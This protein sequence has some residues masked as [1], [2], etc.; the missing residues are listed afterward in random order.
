MP[1]GTFACMVRFA[2]LAQ[3]IPARLIDCRRLAEDPDACLDFVARLRWESGPVCPTCGG[4]DHS[5]LTTRRL[6][7]CR[8]CGRQFSVRVG[9][10]LEDS[11]ISLERWVIALWL[12]A[13][14]SPISGRQLSRATGLTPR[15]AQSVLKRAR[16]ALAA[17]SLERVDLPG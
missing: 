1:V 14:A 10:I 17:G 3:E 2:D 6:W 15:S 13:H 9:T 5:F 12:I 4:F 16:S 8:T 7:K 11:P